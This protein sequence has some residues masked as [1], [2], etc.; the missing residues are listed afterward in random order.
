MDIIVT[1]ESDVASAPAGFKAC[2]NAVCQYYDALLTSPIT[3]SIGVGYGTI[4]GQ[5]MSSGSLGQSSASYQGADYATVAALLRAEG[6]PGAATLPAASPASGT[7]VISSAQAKA[8]GL[9]SYSSVDGNVGF[10]NS[11]NWAY[12]PTQSHGMAFYS[13]DFMGTV[14]HEISEVMGRVSFLNQ[15]GTYTLLDLFRYA[16]AGN[17]QLTTGAPAYFSTDGGNTLPIA[18]NNFET[19]DM[20]D[21]GDWATSNRAVDAFNDDSYN[22]VINPVSAVDKSVMAAIGFTETAASQALTVA[23]AVPSLSAAAAVADIASGADS[24]VRVVDSGAG[25]SAQLDQLEILAGNQNLAAISVTA[26]PI[27]LSVAQLGG[28]SDALKA[29]SGSYTL[30][31]VDRGAAVAADLPAL[32]AGVTAGTISAVYLSD[33][34]YYAFSLTAGQ[35]TADTG[36]FNA[37]AGNFYVIADASGSANLTLAG[38]PG[39]ATVV[40]LSGSPDQ[41]TLTPA[42]DGTSFSMA[43]SGSTDHFS[44]VVALDF[45]AS[46]DFVAAMPA[47]NGGVTGGNITELYGA[48]FGREPDVPGLAYYETVM[49]GNPNLGLTTYAQWFIASPEYVNN[50]AHAYA[51]TSAGDA[52]FITD[53]YQNL[54]H[55]APEAG[56]I[57]YYQNIIARLTAGTTP[58]TAAYTTAWT[59]AHAVVLTDFSQSAEF[60][61]DVRI[62]AQHPA[63]AQHWLY[64]I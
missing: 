57:P 4:G 15:S 38:L 21:L 7:L 27:T 29:I 31:V 10:S 20:G 1:F 50:P 19:G 16:S 62:T 46:R 30:Q 51:Q 54:L 22:S 39:H 12:D 44:N 56:A 49:K 9:G 5:P 18:F 2:V 24:Y 61:G 63:D 55:R 8:L 23:G 35:L 41:Y 11:V 52:Q 60:L 37:M 42:G 32:Q 53:S 47:G 13:Y 43:T 48:V 40:T 33:I 14:E 26:S 36:L 58:G 6:T 3:L 59:Y 64:L 28:D 25:I 45:G 17:R 34:A